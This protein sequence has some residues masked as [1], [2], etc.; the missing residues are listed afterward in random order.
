MSQLRGIGLRLGSES[1]WLYF[2]LLFVEILLFAKNYS[3]CHSLLY[4]LIT[5]TH[6]SEIDIVI[7]F[8]II[9]YIS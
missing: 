6:P 8:T 7:T 5:I 1:N 2:W 9:I 4:L 3:K